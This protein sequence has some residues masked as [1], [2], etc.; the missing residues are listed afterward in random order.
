MAEAPLPELLIRRD[1]E[2]TR[3]PLRIEAPDV[4]AGE[5]AGAASDSH[6]VSELDASSWCDYTTGF[7]R[8]PEGLLEELITEVK[9]EQSEIWRYDHAVPE[10]R[11]GAHLRFSDLNPALRQTALHLSAHYRVRFTDATALYYRNGNDFQGR[12]SDRSLKWLENTLVAGLG[13]GDSRPFQLRP[14]RDWRD[15]VA[16]ADARHDVVLFPGKG[17]LLV[18]GGACQREWVHGVPETTSHEPRISVIWR[19]T[20]RN[21]R[22]DTAPSYRE[23][24]HY[25]DSTNRPGPRSRRV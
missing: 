8:D 4:D 23:G 22:P 16:R 25:S 12:H 15:P 24:R 9:W 11:L 19:W 14:R 20:S 18:M 3:I 1:L 7:I 17:D 13:L 2:P 5:Q 6:G 21:G 10:R